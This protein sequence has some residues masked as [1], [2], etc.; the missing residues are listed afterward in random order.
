[1]FSCQNRKE[2]SC[3]LHS[4]TVYYSQYQKYL[5]TLFFIIKHGVGFFVNIFGHLVCASSIKRLGLA[6]KRSE[7]VWVYGTYLSNFSS[8]VRSETPSIVSKY[9][10][11]FRSQNLLTTWKEN[12]CNY[13][14][15]FSAFKEVYFVRNVI[16][17]TAVLIISL[18]YYLQ[19]LQYFNFLCTTELNF[20]SLI[21]STL[22]TSSKMFTL[23]HAME[24]FYM[25]FR[26]R[27]NPVLN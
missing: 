23:S 27:Y 13:W 9:W 18:C 6:I 26:N 22:Q 14:C 7:K 3:G 19:N 15:N 2:G 10:I 16:L 21:C 11:S 24:F 25:Y 4:V 20:Q 5:N 1:M 12:Y 8:N 17:V